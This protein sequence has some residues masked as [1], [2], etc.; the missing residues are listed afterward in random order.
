MLHL[1]ESIDRKQCQRCPEGLA[2][3]EEKR[4]YSAVVNNFTCREKIPGN[5]KARTDDRAG[6]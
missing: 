3:A 1:P 6:L 5:K 2:S 4:L